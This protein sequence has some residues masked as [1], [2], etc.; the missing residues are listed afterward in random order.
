MGVLVYLHGVFHDIKDKLTLGRA[1]DH[2]FWYNFCN[3]FILMLCATVGCPFIN[4]LALLVFVFNSE[5][6]LEISIWGWLVIIKI[7]EYFNARYKS[8]LQSK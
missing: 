1:G 8:F 6:A 2:K 5:K 7:G 4:I 3:P